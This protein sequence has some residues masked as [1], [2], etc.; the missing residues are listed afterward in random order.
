[1][2]IGQRLNVLVL[3]WGIRRAGSG[4]LTQI[5]EAFDKQYGYRSEEWRRETWAAAAERARATESNGLCPACERPVGRWRAV[6]LTWD[7]Y[8]SSRGQGPD[9]HVAGEQFRLKYHRKCVWHA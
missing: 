9:P 1:M 6:S 8:R 2:K 4:Q 7:E 3:S 5:R